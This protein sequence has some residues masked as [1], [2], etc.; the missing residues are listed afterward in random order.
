MYSF[1]GLIRRTPPQM[2]SDTSVPD[3]HSDTTIFQLRAHRVRISWSI[4]LGK[5][6]GHVPPVGVEPS[7]SAP[8]ETLSTGPGTLLN[9]F[10]TPITIMKSIYLFIYLFIYV[11]ILFY[12]NCIYLGVILNLNCP[13]R[14]TLRTHR[15]L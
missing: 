11:N 13:K 15:F 9:C 3:R 7:P 10:Q 5:S 2:F 4:G 6:F 14:N 1:A 12:I 8:C